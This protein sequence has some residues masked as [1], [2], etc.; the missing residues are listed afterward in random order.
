MKLPKVEAEMLWVHG[1]YDG[2]MSG[3]VMYEGRLCWMKSPGDDIDNIKKSRQYFLYELTSDEV[4]KIVE[5]H[6]E[7]ERLVGTHWCYHCDRGVVRG[8]NH[9]EFYDKY[10]E[11]RL[12]PAKDKEPFARWRR[13]KT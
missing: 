5:R 8:G 11:D 7:F 4:R 13:T 3:V 9:M 10:N 2:P 12:D 1:Y 6:F